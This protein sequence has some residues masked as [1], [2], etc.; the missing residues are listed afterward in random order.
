MRPRATA[1]PL[2]FAIGLTL[3]SAVAA[4]A[5]VAAGAATGPRLRSLDGERATPL[6]LA[7]AAQASEKGALLRLAGLRDAEG[8]PLT[9]ALE[10]G[11][12]F[13]PGFKLYVDGRETPTDAPARLIYLHG[14]AEEWPGS[15]V[16]IGLDARSGGGSGMLVTSGGAFE[17]SL[18]AAAKG[19]LAAVLSVQRA[20]LGGVPRGFVNDV[21]E[22]PGTPAEK[23][24]ITAAAKR[25]IPA[26]GGIFGATLA[27]ETDHEFL[28]GTTVE[29]ATTL[30]HNTIATV[31]ELFERQLGVP[32]AIASLSLYPDESDPWNAPNP[33]TGDRAEVLCEFASFWQAHRPVAAF[34]RNAGLFFTGKDSF[35]ISGQAWR[36]S[37]CNFSAHNSA[38][39]FGGYAIVVRSRFGG[40]SVLTTAHELGH[41]FGSQH[42]HCYHPEID[43]CYGAEAGC[44]AGPE[45]RPEDGGSVMS[46]CNPSAMSLGEPGLYGNQSERVIGVIRSFVDRVA[47]SC[48]GR[49][50]D[51]YAL[52]AVAADDSATLTWV[53]PF[54]NETAWS[55]EQLV[56]NKWKQVKALPANSTTV[57]IGNLKAGD[58]SFRVRAKIRRDV[59]DYSAVVTVTIE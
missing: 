32:L 30:V 47:P 4:P 46:Y 11:S 38:C 2:L 59:S 44:Y 5:A 39:P 14:T 48:L 3:A 43:Q 40:L 45:S 36:A 17:I 50:N 18:P 37:L 29:A 12:V 10:R 13:A 26:P 16:A 51:P 42:T 56:R 20:D 41:V 6:E 35:Q 28:A 54:G 23:A 9:L 33:H 8:R 1:L 57:T 58:N 49:V 25:V 15:S 31:S 52:A 34:P 19:T 22:P 27:V 53:D 7:R 21:L 24:A 55:V